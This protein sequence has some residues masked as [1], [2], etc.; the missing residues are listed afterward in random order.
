MLAQLLC[1]SVDASVVALLAE[2]S[3]LSS[4]ALL[5]HRRP[6][7]RGERLAMGSQSQSLQCICITPGTCLESFCDLV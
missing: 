1:E 2:V 6:C 7:I 3:D 4:V 5:R